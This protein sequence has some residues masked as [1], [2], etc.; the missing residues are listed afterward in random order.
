MILVFGRSGQ[1]GTELAQMDDVLALGRGDAD[2]TDPETCVQHILTHRPSAV[3]NAAAYTAVDN[4]E[5]AEDL[6]TLINATTP[7]AMAKAC[8]A[9]SIPFIHIST[10][11]VF[12][13]AHQS[14]HKPDDRPNPLN[15]YGQS[16]RLGE[17]LIARSGVDYA[18]LRTSWVISAHGANFVKSMVR[19]AQNH[20]ALSVVNDQIGG[21]TPAA[22]LAEA[23]IK[24]AHDLTKNPSH[25]GVYHLS[26]QPDVSW[27]EFAKTIFDYTGHKIDLTAIPTSEYP[28]HAQRPKNSRL[29]CETTK[30]TF[31]IQRPIWKTDLMKILQ[32]LGEIQ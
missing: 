5:A 28:T 29:D 11:Y 9:V 30:L 14:P 16:K 31:D 18:I 21:P 24:I 23:C 3:I 26:G 7:E 32:D 13:G 6:A 10:D 4:A 25:R 15:A 2:L 19:A 12:D 27:F 8:R 17:D 1:V 20:S 22:R